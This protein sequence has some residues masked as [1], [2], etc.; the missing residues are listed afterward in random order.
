LEI[1]FKNVGKENLKVKM[2]YRME[3]ALEDKLVFKLLE[4]Q[5]VV[6]CGASKKLRASLKL[7]K[8]V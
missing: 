7:L 3:R 1:P 4:E 2:R 5:M 6:L 8:E